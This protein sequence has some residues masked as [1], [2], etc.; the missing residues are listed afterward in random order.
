VLFRS[1]DVSSLEGYD[2]VVLGAPVYTG[3]VMADLTGFVARHQEA[4]AGLP[5][6][7]FTAGIAPVYPKTGEVT[8]FTDQL[9]TAL[10]PNAPIAVTM[11]AGTLD[12]ERLSLIERGLTTLLKVPVGDFRN[13]DAIAAWSR[14][15][16]GT[17]GLGA[18]RKE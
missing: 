4:L 16:P 1:K 15:L 17:M 10:Q 3:S 11:F 13:W 6:A 7:A 14:E 18:G 5:V 9:V 2:G 8:T 12:R